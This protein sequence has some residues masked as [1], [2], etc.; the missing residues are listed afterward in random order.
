M[1]KEISKEELKNMTASE[2]LHMIAKDTGTPADF[3][4]GTPECT[5]RE[6]MEELQSKRDEMAQI[7]KELENTNLPAEKRK[8]MERRVANLRATISVMESRLR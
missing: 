3:Y 1:A 7:I 6:M 8:S 4:C 2:L 5:Y